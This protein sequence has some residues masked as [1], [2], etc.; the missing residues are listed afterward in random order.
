MNS[1]F[2]LDS[3]P[4]AESLNAFAEQALSE[5]EREPILSHLAACSRCRQVIFLA[6]QAASA[7]EM[8]EVAAATPQLDRQAAYEFA[9]AMVPAAAATAGGASSEMPQKPR[10]WWSSGW[11]LAWVP[12]VALVGVVGIAVL[13][14][15]QSV[16]PGVE[17]EA[18]IADNTPQAAPQSQPIS[19]APAPADE[20]AGV[21]RAAAEKM[22]PPVAAKKES[23]RTASADALSA[24]VAPPPPAPVA[25]SAMSVSSAYLN[26]VTPLPPPQALGAEMQSKNAAMSQRA[27]SPTATS[28]S[29]LVVNENS[30]KSTN[31]SSAPDAVFGTGSTA[32]TG[33]SAAQ[34]AF[35]SATLGSFVSNR[36]RA[37]A[38][39]DATSARM[40]GT[41]PLPSGL[42]TV[43]IA[44][45]QHR[46]L[47]IDSS[48]T[49]FLSEDSGDHWQPVSH[50][51]SGRAVAVRLQNGS[52]INGL[53]AVG[54]TVAASED[55]SSTSNTPSKSSVDAISAATAPPAVF[56]IVNDDGLIWI[57]TDGKNWKAK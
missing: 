6:Q 34:S 54:A 25:V 29:Q 47:A 42:R 38:T 17:P 31:G 5:R 30:L 19:A 12:A 4:D 22:K 8:R 27:A 50:Q 1:T 36:N 16:K 37:A 40:T 7:S 48:G 14:H 23:A 52:K 21:N 43:S 2:Q 45:A 51:W 53:V 15:M 41:T 33:G 55:K 44:T 9:A 13:V 39:T 46:T 28:R 18:N 57:S 56:E 49:L 35:R 24:Q 26:S 32:Q 10:S 11:R 3:H 20:Q